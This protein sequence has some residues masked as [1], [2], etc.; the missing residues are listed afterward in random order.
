[1]LIN[2]ETQALVSEGDFRNANPHTA[3]PA[4]L[5]DEVLASFGYANVVYEAHPVAPYG[6]RVV[7]HPPIEIDGVWKVLCT[8]EPMND[9]ELD[10]HK[11][12][13]KS[14]ISNAVQQRL[15]TFAQTR[16]YDNINS[17]ASYATSVLPA[18]PSPAETRI[19]AEGVYASTIRIQTWA[20]LE[21][22][23]DE[24]DAVVVPHPETYADVEPHLPVLAWPV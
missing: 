2:K 11:A 10:M 23:F 13:I 5:T 18:T 9:K 19:H 17:A 24:V 15:D 16:G 20:A 6:Q 1:M 22:Y 4:V 12:C 7:E 14:D 21:T 8:L 3:F